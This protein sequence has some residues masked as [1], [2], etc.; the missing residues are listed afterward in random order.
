VRKT[1][2]RDTGQLCPKLFEW[3]I[4][5]LF[6]YATTK[7][8]ANKIKLYI[9]FLGTRAIEL[10]EKVAKVTSSYPLCDNM[11]VNY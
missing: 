11:A 7:A 3:S 6:V 10:L 1:S 5:Q 9:A 8:D 4:A 2:L